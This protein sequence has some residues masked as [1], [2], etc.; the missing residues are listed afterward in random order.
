[1][2]GAERSGP[3]TV[4]RGDGRSGAGGATS[5]TGLGARRWAWRQRPCRRRWAATLE[6]GEGDGDVGVGDSATK[7]TERA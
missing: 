4:G 2:V 5:T 7:K 3:T 1:V 6:V